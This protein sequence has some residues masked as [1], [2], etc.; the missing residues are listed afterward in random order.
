MLKLEKRL[1][2]QTFA[3]V[4]EKLDEILMKEENE[5]K[6]TNIFHKSVD[7]AYLSIDYYYEIHTSAKISLL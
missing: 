3:D 5:R 2:I 4:C 7:S 1:A 6:K